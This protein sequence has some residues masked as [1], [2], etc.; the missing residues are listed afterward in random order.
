MDQITIAKELKYKVDP[1]KNHDYL[2]SFSCY[3][4]IY[5]LSSQALPHETYLFTKLS[6]FC[7]SI[8]WALAGW[9]KKRLN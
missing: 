9:L 1:E 4:F 6:M 3:D 7:P 8:T 5:I 2:F